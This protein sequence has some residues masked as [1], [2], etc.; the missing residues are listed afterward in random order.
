MSLSLAIRN[1]NRCVGGIL[2]SHIA[3]RHGPEGL[4][5][6]TITVEFEGSAGQS[7][8]GWLAPGGDLHA[9]GATP[10]TTPAR[11]SPG[12]CSRSAPG[13]AWASTSRPSRT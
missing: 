4:P 12:A 8:G 2:S 11:A 9:A 6:D 3:R 13:R 10:R 7:F 5:E 1:R